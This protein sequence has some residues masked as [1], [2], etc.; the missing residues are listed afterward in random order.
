VGLCVHCLKGWS[1]SSGGRACKRSFCAYGLGQQ[2]WEG[3][4]CRV[5]DLLNVRIVVMDELYTSHACTVHCCI[6]SCGV[7]T[8]EYNHY[9][10]N[11]SNRE[12]PLSHSSFHASWAGRLL[13]MY[14]AKVSN[15]KDIT[16]ESHVI[17]YTTCH[18]TQSKYL[19][20]L[21]YI[22]SN[23]TLDVEGDDT[24]QQSCGA[25]TCVYMYCRH[26]SPSE[27]G[28]ERVCVCASV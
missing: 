17:M 22:P 12:S 1:S 21:G 28:R 15:N 11:F 7:K 14:S 6:R 3:T 10:L 26:E 25:S 27:M 8:S 2:R 18:F 20:L 19:G 9:Y 23:T 16:G 4:R 5:V 24:R 13:T